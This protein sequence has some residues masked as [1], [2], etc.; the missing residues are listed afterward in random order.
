M[1]KHSVDSVEIMVEHLA[2]SKCSDPLDV[3]YF[4]EVLS[5]YFALG[6]PALFSRFKR[7][8]LDA[9]VKILPNLTVEQ[10]FEITHALFLY[11]RTNNSTNGDLENQSEINEF[12]FQPFKSTL[13]QVLPSFNVSDLNFSP[14]EDTYLILTRHAVT[15]GMYAPGKHIYAVC[16]ALL[17]AKKRVVLVNF[18]NQDEKF[19][20]LRKYSDFSFYG[21]ESNYSS[22]QSFYA[23][24]ELINEIRPAE[25]ITEIELSVINLIE[26]IGISSDVCLLS[27]GFYQT[28]WFDKKYL[29]SELYLDDMQMRDELVEIPQ[30]HSL[31]ILA[32]SL[33][34][35]QI[36][37]IRTS[38]G[39]QHNF[40]LG[41]FARYEMFT[42]QFLLF[43]KRALDL[44]PNSVL[45]LAGAN[46]KQIVQTY[47]AEEIEQKKVIL[48]GP[49]KTH[50]LGWVVDV[51][52]DPF[53]TV[54]GFAALESLAKGKPV[55]TKECPGLGNYKRS[56][57]RDLI[58]KKESDLIEALISMAECKNEYFKW[59]QQSKNLAAGFD[60]STALAAAICN[61][62]RQRNLSFQNA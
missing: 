20:E 14:N 13:E 49:V 9:Y 4:S 61:S 27:S 32:P 40:V 42:S 34:Q 56:R 8:L 51:F 54:A 3:N 33:A 35:T 1:S 19:L 31:E 25:I 38:L 29:G 59:S 23:L 26:A 53:P 48:F 60:N 62:P 41:S 47:L 5:A 39:I 21:C 11:V 12:V 17:K 57:V 58:F 7:Q 28:P 30:T 50:V 36:D 15:Q 18:G 24:R 6:R 52:L 16:D 37:Q 46:D 44:V 55:V 2:K 43:A 22:M 45:V 10:C